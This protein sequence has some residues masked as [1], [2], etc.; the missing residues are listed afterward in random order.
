M[1][2]F[3]GLPLPVKVFVKGV[4]MAEVIRLGQSLLTYVDPFTCN[5]VF[6]PDAVQY[7]PR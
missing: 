3:A 7:S 5:D 6:G 1:L 4:H 2:L